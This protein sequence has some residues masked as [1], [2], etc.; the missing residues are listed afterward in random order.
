MMD[1]ELSR[2]LAWYMSFSIEDLGY[3]DH[4]ERRNMLSAAESAGTFN[5]L[6]SNIKSKIMEAE[7]SYTP[8]EFPTLPTPWPLRN[9]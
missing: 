6:P 5:M 4:E 7:L 8:E 9:Q 3:I 1:A 2:R